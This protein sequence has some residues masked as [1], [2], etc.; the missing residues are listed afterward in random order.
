MGHDVPI[1]LIPKTRLPRMKSVEIPVCGRDN[2]KLEIRASFYSKWGV[3]DSLNRKH[4]ER[5]AA[6]P[7]YTLF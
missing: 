2:L 4:W 5:R 1:F 7:V 3:K 6:E